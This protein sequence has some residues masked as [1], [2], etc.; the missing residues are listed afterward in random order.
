MTAPLGAA[1]QA[2]SERAT[3]ITMDTTVFLAVLGAA[4]MHAGWNAIVKVGGTEYTVVR[5]GMTGAMADL[6]LVR[7]T[8]LRIVRDGYY[9]ERG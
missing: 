5:V 8:A 1:R 4:L 2:K 3:G 6:H 9:Q 7:T